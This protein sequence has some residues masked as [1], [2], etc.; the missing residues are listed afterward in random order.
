MAKKSQK[1]SVRYEKDQLGCM[2]GL[3]SI[4][5]FRHGRPTWKLIS[6][7]RHGS[8]QAVGTGISR[9]KFK[10]LSNLDEN[11]KTL[12]K[13]IQ[14]DNESSK[15]IVAVD[16]CKPSVKKLMEEEMSGKQDMKKERSERSNDVVETRQ[17]DSSQSRK[18]HKRSKTTRK[19]SRD[20]DN[21][22]LNAFENSESGCSCNQN[23]EQK[24]RSN[25]GMDEIIEEVCCQIHQKYIND[26][27]HDVNGETPAKPNCKHSDFEEKL[28]VAIK[29]FTNHKFTDGKQ[30]A[31]D[32]KI[33]H[34]KELLDALEV[35]SSDEELR[36]KL[37]QDPNSLLAK[38]VQKLKDAQIE[39]DEECV[40]F[41]ESKLSEQ[42]LGDVKQSEELVNRKRRYF[43]SR[44]V[45]PQ[46]RNPSK[47]NEDSEASKMIVILKPGPPALQNS[48]IEDSTTPESHNIVRNRG[49]SEELVPTF[50]FRK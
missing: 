28:C 4:F 12:T 18:D 35:L 49:P 17:S 2:W 37:L 50:F 14:D 15:A 30:L 5:D 25:V 21:H 8:K 19:K 10:S 29:E 7:K 42:K 48:E 16:A 44:K 24:P 11:F 36:L 13:M 34:F 1:R 23:R 20:M 39:K 32:Q 46:E 47:E 26:A 43:F 3:I 45:K 40:S 38:Q 6:D 22:N 41:A 9:N 33:H 27:N 31:E